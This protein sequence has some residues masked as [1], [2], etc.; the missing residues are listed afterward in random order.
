MTSTPHTGPSAAASPSVEA[1]EGKLRAQAKALEVINEVSRMFAAELDLNR[2]VQAITD[3]TTRLTQADFGAFF[4]NVKAADGESYSLYTLS[5]V[6]R[7]HFSKFPM[8]RNTALFGPTF[9][10]EGTVLIDDVLQDPRYGKSAPYYG[11]PQGHLPVRSYLAAPVISRS[12]EV[13]GGL[14]FGHSEPARFTT[15]HAAV[16]EGLC[17]YAAIAVDNARLFERAR[18]NELANARLAAI[19]QSSDDA[20]VG[21]DLNG[22]VQT[23]NA[24][25]ERMFGYSAS[26][27]IGKP[28]LT[29][30]PPERTNEESDILA[31]LRQ[32]ER[33]DHFE[34]V[35]RTKTGRL[36]DVSVSVSPIRDSQGL[37][38][39]ASKV[40]RDITDRRR[41]DEERERLLAS[42]RSARAQA[43]RHSQLKDEFL[44]TLSH[45][46]RTPLTAILGW[47]HLL[48]RQPAQ[49]A[50]IAHGLTVIERNARLQAQ[51]IEDLLDMSRI[52]SGKLRM[53]VQSV[54]PGAVIHAALDSVRPAADAKGVRLAVVLDSGGANVTG[55][56]SRLQQVVWNLLSNAVKFTSKGGLV[57]VS[58]ERRGSHVVITVEDT[59]E[60]IAPEFLPL[61][62]ER[63]R[64]ADASTT[65][66]HAGLG[67]GLA[68]VKHLTELHGGT[69][70]AFSAGVG[71]GAA[72]SVTLPIRA[73]AGQ[74][75]ADHGH[76]AAGTNEPSLAGIRALVVDDEPDARELIKRVLQQAGVEVRTAGSAAEA[77][78]L[79]RLEVP[80]LIVS[81]IGMPG[82]DG[83]SL[84]R[85]VRHLPEC[86]G[87]TVP[88]VALTA[89]AQAEDRRRALLSGFQMHISKPVEPSELIAVIAS[90]TRRV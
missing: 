28:I 6:P 52:I 57:R 77:F 2:L 11:M 34:T 84:V 3:A 23:W 61:V 18:A 62:F 53:K 83:Y 4:Y 44:A 51:L 86:E 89:F 39:G 19:V 26:E 14:F 20:I 33:V 17:G 37:I 40:A 76:A 55:D 31:R 36:I 65:R 69:V 43:E 85:R 79:I 82:E 16:L 67:L 9:R 88:A 48:T 10:G 29:I 60:G 64:Q 38:V 45:E 35:R 42:E 7:E 70:A 47:A 22:I 80:D 73:T 15:N 58:M 32:G 75:G 5:G 8:P 78:E 50:D 59:G 1:E 87:G 68:I 90:I 46:L 71:K 74:S 66:Q 72:F 63:F 27:M 13:L 21:K 30:I 56:P 41:V 24:G 12:G 81:D 54:E 49:P 25:A